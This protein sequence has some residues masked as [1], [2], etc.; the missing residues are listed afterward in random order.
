MF[1]AIDTFFSQFSERSKLLIVVLVFCLIGILLSLWLGGMIATSVVTIPAI[2]SILEVT[3]GVWTPEGGG[4]SKL[5]LASLGVALAAVALSPQWQP[6]V[7]FT[8]KPLFEEYP[9]LKD[10]LHADAPSITA[11]LFLVAVIF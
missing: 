10:K 9:T 11:L 4:K 5:G 7:N 1:A 2:L 6:L 8:L 3:K